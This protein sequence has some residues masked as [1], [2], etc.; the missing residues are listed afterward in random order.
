MMLFWIVF[1]SIA[2][3]QLTYYIVKRTHWSPVRTS[4]ATALTFALIVHL[5][6]LPKHE[7]LAAAFLGSSFLGMANQET[8]SERDLFFGSWIFALIF[9][10]VLPFNIGLGGALGTAAFITCAVVRGSYLLAMK[11]RSSSA[12]EQTE[13][14]PQENSQT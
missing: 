2:S 9:Q 13:Q 1:I 11:I 8:F 10:F 5:L 4:A 12:E 3:A 14:R 6:D 7:T